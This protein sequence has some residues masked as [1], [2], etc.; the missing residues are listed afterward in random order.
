M[1]SEIIDKFKIIIGDK[2]YD[3]ERG[4]SRYC[5]KHG[6]LAIIP[7]RNEDVPIYR[8]KEENRKRMKRH[9]PEEYKRRS[10]VE[11]VHSVIKRK[12]G[13]FVS[14]RTPELAEKEI[15]LKI[16]AYNIRRTIILNYSIVISIIFRFS[17]ELLPSLISTVTS[18]PSL[19]PASSIITLSKL[20]FSPIFNVNLFVA[21]V[22]R[23]SLFLEYN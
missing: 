23:T 7:V 14:S 10:I 4:K 19:I 12:S 8:T 18:S 5:Q 3:S 13:S 22:E 1:D 2:G 6:L 15:V 20:V 21:C 17:T 11:K 9:L 16:I